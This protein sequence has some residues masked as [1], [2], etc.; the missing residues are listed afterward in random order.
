MAPG[1][2]KNLHYYPWEFEAVNGPKTE[3]SK[4][5]THHE[6]AR[7]PQEGN[8]TK[9]TQNLEWFM[10]SS[11]FLHPKVFFCQHSM[12]IRYTQGQAL[13]LSVRISICD[14]AR[15]RGNITPFRCSLE[16]NRLHLLHTSVVCPLVN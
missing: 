7:Q 12:G 3:V 8:T 10:K 15:R 11:V 5:G 1:H 13:T 16:L 9:E 2:A 14:R 4:V 6:G